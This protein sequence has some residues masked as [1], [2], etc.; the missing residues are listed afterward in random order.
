MEHPNSDEVPRKL[1]SRTHEDA[2]VESAGKLDDTIGVRPFLARFDPL[3]AHEDDVSVCA[4][5]MQYLSDTAAPWFHDDFGLGSD[6]G[7]GQEVGQPFQ[8]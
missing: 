4:G 8:L 3:K 6:T 2:G 1:T 5:L 7:F